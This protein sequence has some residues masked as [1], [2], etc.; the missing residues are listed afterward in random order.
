M[1]TST[2]P[3]AT[4]ENKDMKYPRFFRFLMLAGLVLAMALPSYAQEEPPKEELPP[5][6]SKAL[7]LTF[8]IYS[9]LDN[10]TLLVTDPEQVA[11]IERRLSTAMEQGARMD[12]APEPVLG[13]N[14]IMVEDAAQVDAE[15]GTWYV[16]KYDVVSV[17]GG[18]PSTLPP[19][20]SSR[21]ALD[22][23]DL[24]ISLGVRA[25]VVDQATLD[26]VRNPKQ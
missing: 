8:Q 11:D 5:A 17:D 6:D 1:K 19:P 3:L 15:D 18:D 24:L 20:T 9:G 25:G 12:L 26:V 4:Q 14:G 22:L 10:P 23:E 7:L 21:E 16:V 2:R 13:Y